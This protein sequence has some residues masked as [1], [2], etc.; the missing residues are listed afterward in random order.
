MDRNKLAIL[1]NEL[2]GYDEAGERLGVDADLVQRA[3]EGGRLNNFEV[4]EIDKG[5]ASLYDAGADNADLD[6]LYLFGIADAPG[7]RGLT[8]SVYHAE[9]AFYNP[10]RENLFRAAFA[11]DRITQDDLYDAVDF[12]NDG[13]LTEKIQDKILTWLSE[14]DENGEPH[15][16]KEFLDAYR[17][18]GKD[19]FR[20]DLEESAFWEWFRE[21]FY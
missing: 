10:E 16:A 19:L 8:D 17:A 14:D 7:Q 4:A 15:T 1:T 5:F 13:Y 12:F 18:D 21:T 3:V 6:L 9:S 2:G 11:E 20:E